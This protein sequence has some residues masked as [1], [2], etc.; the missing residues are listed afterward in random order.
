[1]PDGN[2]ARSSLIT[3]AAWMLIISLVLFFLPAINGLIGGLVGGYKAGTTGRALTAAVLPAIAVFFC[4]WGLMALFG[5]T[6]LGFI[7]GLA[8]GV[9]ALISSI[10]LIVGAL[11]GGAISPKHTA[12]Y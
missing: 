5:Y 11:L 1:M 12:G 10:G 2:H 7:S 3:S 9:W 8:V 4:V 6:A